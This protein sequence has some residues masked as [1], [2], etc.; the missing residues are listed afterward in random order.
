M[1]NAMF[2]LYLLL[3]SKLLTILQFAEKIFFTLS[4]DE[5]VHSHKK[6]SF[7]DNIFVQHVFLVPIISECTV[8]KFC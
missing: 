1:N 8:N 6:I 5:L 7:H 4:C 2:C 3:A